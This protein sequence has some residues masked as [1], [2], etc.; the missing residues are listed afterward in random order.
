MKKPKLLEALVQ[1]QSGAKNE[2]LNE[3]KEKQPEVE[4]G[5]GGGGILK[6]FLLREVDTPLFLLPLVYPAAH[7][8]AL[9]F[10]K[11][12]SM[13]FAATILTRENN[14]LRIS[15]SLKDLDGAQFSK[16][17]IHPDVLQ[18]MTTNKQTLAINN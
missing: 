11:V 1:A 6:P 3:P 2:E 18:T 13:Q 5:Q 14:D 15:Y 12:P 17:H 9:L 10:T 8:W 16:P 7:G 4:E